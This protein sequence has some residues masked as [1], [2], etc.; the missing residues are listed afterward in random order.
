MFVLKIDFYIWHRHY[1]HSMLYVRIFPGLYIT[2]DLHPCLSEFQDYR[3]W[4]PIEFLSTRSILERKKTI[5]ISDLYNRY[6]PIHAGVVGVTF[7]L[8]LY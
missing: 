2:R 8:V 5:N 6:S 4:M 3:K 1:V 7:Y